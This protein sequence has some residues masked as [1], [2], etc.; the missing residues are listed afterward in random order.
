MQVIGV[1]YIRSGGSTLLYSS[2]GYILW[3]NSWTGSFAPR[4]KLAL[5]NNM[6]TGPICLGKMLSKRGIP[7]SRTCVLDRQWPPLVPI[8]PSPQ[9]LLHG[10][11]FL[12]P[13]FP[14]LHR[15]AARLQICNTGLSIHRPIPLPPGIPYRDFI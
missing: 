11:P 14:T 12:L 2:A 5:A 15:T 6:G 7:E 1:L 10:L 4:Q 13:R 9:H 8:L 3:I